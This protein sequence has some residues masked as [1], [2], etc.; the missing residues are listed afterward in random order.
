MLQFWLGEE[1]TNIRSFVMRSSQVALRLAR[2]QSD[3]LSAFLAQLAEIYDL[4]LEHRTHALETGP[5]ACLLEQQ[6]EL[7]DLRRHSAEYE[8]FPAC[9]QRDPLRRVNRAY[10]VFFRRCRQG[11]AP[12]Y[13]LDRTLRFF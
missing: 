5:K 6:A 1:K 11:E 4:C 7:K 13:P 12:G 2:R 9:I 3:L 10:E 8:S